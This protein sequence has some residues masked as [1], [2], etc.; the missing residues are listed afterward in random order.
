MAAEDKLVLV[1]RFEDEG[2]GILI[3]KVLEDEGI[4][5]EIKSEQIP[6]MD[7]I[8]KTA[9]GYWGDLMVLEEEA[10]RAREI[11]RSYLEEDANEDRAGSE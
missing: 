3:R 9:R 6:W 5:S 1:W 2:L 10:D 4:R 11:I 7:G 8:M